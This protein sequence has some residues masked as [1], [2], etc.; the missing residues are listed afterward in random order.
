VSVLEVGHIAADTH[1]G[2]EE[3]DSLDLD[4]SVVPADKVAES[5]HIAGMALRAGPQQKVL[6]AGQ[7]LCS[8][9]VGDTW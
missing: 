5:V 7:V 2:L 3:L 1:E 9:A 8:L 4:R 6:E